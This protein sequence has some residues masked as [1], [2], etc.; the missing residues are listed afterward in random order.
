[1]LL[2]K[3][4]RGAKLLVLAGLAV[5]LVICERS[6]TANP[7]IDFFVYR[8]GAQLGLEGKQPYFNPLL[9]ERVAAQF[10]EDET[11]FASNCGF[12]LPPQAIVVFLPFAKMDWGQAQVLWFIVL[13]T[14]GFLCGLLAYSFGRSQE[15]L[16]SG[17]PIIVLAVWMNPITM[18]S[19][20]VGQTTLLFVGCIVLG[21][22][23]FEN[24]SP[25]LGTFLWS[26]TFIKPH[27]ALPFLVLAWVLGGWKR[28]FGIGLAVVAW[29]VL[30]GLIVTGTL[31]GAYALFRTYL[32]YLGAGHKQVIFNLVAENYQIPSWNRML[33]AAGGPAIDLKIWMTLTGFAVW[34][35]LVAGRMWRARALGRDRLDP[36]YLAAVTAVGSL[37]FPQ[38]L[39]YE[40]II[41]ALLTPL[42]LQH[43]DANRRGDAYALIAMLLFLMLPMNFTNRIADFFGL[44][45]QSRSRTLLRSHKCFGM[46][47]LATWLLVRGPSEPHPHRPENQPEPIA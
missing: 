18:P 39:A 2:E 9:Q 10:P 4:S 33:A 37:F 12:F 45:E 29:N 22:Y 16:G 24:D 34:G 3:T 21:H 14:M 35:L 43:F 40:M 20:V 42:I 6:M 31:E 36:A 19:L 25:R 27:L 11:G 17:W 30:G 28:P 5:Y 1:M 32:E 44:G 41:L 13:T 47:L 38:V 8:T 15:H 23:A 46:A 7:Q 26:I